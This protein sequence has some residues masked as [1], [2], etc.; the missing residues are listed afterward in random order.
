MASVVFAA[1]LAAYAAAA[2]E[3]PAVRA[4]RAR[5]L[6]AVRIVAQAAPVAAAAQG[7]AVAETLYPAWPECAS[8]KR[9]KLED[10]LDAF[11]DT[12]TAVPLRASSERGDG[13]RAWY[14]GGFV[15]HKLIAAKLSRTSYLLELS[16][17]LRLMV[18]IQ[19]RY[20]DLYAVLK[21][22]PKKNG[23]N[24]ALATLQA[25]DEAAIAA[26]AIDRLKPRAVRRRLDDLQRALEQTWLL[27]GCY[28]T[29]PDK[30]YRADFLWSART[31]V[32]K[33]KTDQRSRATELLC[34]AFFGR[35]SPL[36]TVVAMPKPFTLKAGFEANFG[37]DIWHPKPTN[38]RMIWQRSRMVYPF[39]EAAHRTW[40]QQL[41]GDPQPSG[42]TS[43]EVAQAR[44][45][46]CPN[47]AAAVG[48]LLDRIARAS[49]EEKVLNSL[50]YWLIDLVSVA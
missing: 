46:I 43:A 7:A 48:Q 11:V 49:P 4:S 27:L 33:V 45:A 30:A 31:V 50:L 36:F 8:S 28:L 26:L 6:R 22:V 37:V 25:A 1:L 39:L 32:E 18:G 35:S 34:L 24:P 2:L 13:W 21:F 40:L 42:L 3:S 10:V 44:A 47:H 29:L 12:T 41:A 17:L 14:D 16:L 15:A 20:P 23:L 19:E 9:S 38:A 5:P